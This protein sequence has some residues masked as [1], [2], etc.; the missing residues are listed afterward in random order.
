MEQF[1]SSLETGEKY[2]FEIPSLGFKEE[3]P[4][5]NVPTRGGYL[6]I[7]SLNLVGMAAW[8]ELFGEAIAEKVRSVFGDDAEQMTYL[9][10]VEKSLQLAQVV[11]RKLGQSV[12]G[13]AYNR[14]KPHMEVK[15]SR[16]RPHIQVGGGSIT[17]GDKF[18]VLYERDVN[19]LRAATNGVVIIDDVV[20]TG[21]TIAAMATLLDQVSERYELPGEALRIR[22]IFCVA[23]EGEIKLPLYRGLAERVHAL[24]SLP[25]PV[26]IPE[27]NA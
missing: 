16:R 14:I 15:S 11:S 1:Y 19:L 5:V 18:L 25:E 23:R 12:I 22:G 27:G 20:S 2:T 24:G 26:F 10:A 17:S 6:K 8:N 3:L 7:A 21:G 13:V 4:Y 9:T